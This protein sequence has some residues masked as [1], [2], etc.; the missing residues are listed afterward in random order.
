MSS[1]GENLEHEKSANVD[2]DRSKNPVEEGTEKISF[3]I[4]L[5][6]VSKYNSTYNLNNTNSVNHLSSI[7]HSYF[8][9]SQWGGGQEGGAAVT[10]GRVASGG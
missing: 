10:Q 9:A 3:Q 6:D 4:L 5:K 1:R 7:I 2:L 8:R